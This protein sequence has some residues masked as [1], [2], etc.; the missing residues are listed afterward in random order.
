LFFND[1]AGNPLCFIAVQKGRCLGAVLTFENAPDIRKKK[2]CSLEVIMVDPAFR[3]KGI[4][5]FLLRKL[6]DQCRARQ[7]NVISSCQNQIIFPGLHPDRHQE[8]I[9]FL[10][11]NGFESP[12]FMCEMI[13][14]RE[15]FKKPPFVDR[16]ERQHTAGNLSF[17]IVTPS[18]EE[19]FLDFLKQE[20]PEMHDRYAG[21]NGRKCFKDLPHQGIVYVE[22][23]GQI[24]GCSRYD[25]LANDLGP[26]A[27]YRKFILSEMGR[28]ADSGSYLLSD[29]RVMKNWRHQG[30][31][32]LLAYRSCEKIFEKKGKIILGAISTPAF[33]LP[34]GA[35]KINP[36]LTLSASAT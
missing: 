36:Y 20:A 34:F 7:I 19:L 17:G 18:K 29:L 23:D 25:C 28:L 24:I 21:K 10:I 26:A 8:T 12:S 35:R 16:I 32:S 5:S 3:R 31:G 6:R 15:A 4:G 1:R 9:D 22:R 11:H 30:V 27:A 14:T 13:L 2:A 33:F